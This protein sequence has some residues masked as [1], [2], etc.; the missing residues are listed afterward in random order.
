MAQSAAQPLKAI[1][2]TVNSPSDCTQGAAPADTIKIRK[3]FKKITV[4]DP[5]AIAK[6][7][8]PTDPTTLSI[9]QGKTGLTLCFLHCQMEESD[10]IE[11]MAF[12]LCHL[13]LAFAYWYFPNRLTPIDRSLQKPIK[14]AY[15]RGDWL[16]IRNI[17]KGKFGR[18]IDGEQT[19]QFTMEFSELS[20]ESQLGIMG[21]LEK[22]GYCALYRDERIT[23]GGNH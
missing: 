20:Y 9:I 23:S 6:G 11:K 16:R 2:E 10:A 4:K 13:N 5:T 8:A 1:Q 7:G 22:A 3:I 12:T 21:I 14:S 19:A 17:L 18:D 15:K